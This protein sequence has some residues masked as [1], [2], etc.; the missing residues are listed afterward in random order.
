MTARSPS[1][2]YVGALSLLEV[3]SHVSQ[4]VTSRWRTLLLVIV[5][6]IEI[7]LPSD[8]RVINEVSLLPDGGLS[9]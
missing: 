9:S 5:T 1:N 8:G 7:A 3:F 6:Q 2:G 4:I